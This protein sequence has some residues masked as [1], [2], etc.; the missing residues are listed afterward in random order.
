LWEK[1]KVLEINFIKLLNFIRSII[2]FFAVEFIFIKEGS[3][4]M[5]FT[6]DLD[7]G[8]RKVQMALIYNKHL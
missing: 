5:L 3:N 6:L 8:G 2:A 4:L 1:R 7:L